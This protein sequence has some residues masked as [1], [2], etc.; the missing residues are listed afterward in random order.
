[1]KSHAWT[2]AITIFAAFT[3]GATFLLALLRQYGLVEA[4][5][6]LGVGAEVFFLSSSIGDRLENK[7]E[8]NRI[9]TVAAISLAVGV[10]AC[11]LIRRELKG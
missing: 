10:V 7:A 2:I 6:S 9:R 8:P 11:F 4:A 1:M 5:A 3:C